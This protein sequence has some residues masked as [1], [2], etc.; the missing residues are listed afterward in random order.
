[1]T[2]ALRLAH[3]LG[4]VSGFGCH[5]GSGDPVGGRDAGPLPLPTEDLPLLACLQTVDSV[6]DCARDAD[7]GSGSCVLDVARA[8]PDRGPIPL[9]CG[10][11]QGLGEARDACEIRADCESGLCAMTGTCLAPCREHA[12]CATGLFCLPME[13]RLSAEALSPVMACARNL[14]FEADVQLSAGPTTGTLGT[15][16]LASLTVTDTRGT[17]MVYLKPDCGS[18][19]QVQ[20]LSSLEG[21]ELFDLDEVLNGRGSLNPVSNVGPLV[22]ILLPNNPALTGYQ[23]GLEIDFFVSSTTRVSSLVAARAPGTQRVLDLNLFYVG[24]GMD[25][26][27]GGFHPGAP[28]VAGLLSDLRAMYEGVGITL[29][30][31][32]QIDVVGELRDELSVLETEV[33]R[34]GAGNTVGLEVPGLDQ[35]F[36]LSI[37][38]EYGGINLF[39]VSD[40][41]DL[42]GIAGGIPG[43][44]GVHGTPASGVA[45]ALDVVGLEQAPA[46]AMHEMSHQMGLFHTSEFDGSSVEPLADT[47]ACL[48]DRDQNGDGV[49]VPAECRGAGADNLMFWSGAGLK[50]SAEQRRVLQTSIV[51]R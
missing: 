6:G 16:E 37:G 38:L 51:L 13:A 42:L 5:D 21:E 18:Q 9:T 17:S 29:G 19:V 12:D 15:D 36:E 24:A 22:P 31:V 49:L 30:T 39:L 47:P 2:S 10:A 50:L 28:Q 45:I 14:A 40:M 26:E 46:V 7:C 3:A 25:D 41:G 20:G 44:L 33:V 8:V 4:A 27:E 32:R 1:M 11:L 48:T 43:A 34:D 23:S 35:L